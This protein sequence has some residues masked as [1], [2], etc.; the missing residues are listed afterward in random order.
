MGEKVFESPQV[1]HGMDEG[2]E[3]EETS[4]SAGD[5][6]RNRYWIFNII[7]SIVW[8]ILVWYIRFSGFFGYIFN[9]PGI[10]F[11]SLGWAVAGFCKLDMHWVGLT[12]FHYLCPNHL[13]KQK[14]HGMPSYLY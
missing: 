13:D 11:S 1:V 10:I 8:I 12:D 6:L 14:Q 7:W 4:I 3:L 5:I 9:P 2:K